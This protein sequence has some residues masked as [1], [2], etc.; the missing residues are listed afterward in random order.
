MKGTDT[1]MKKIIYTKYSNERARQ[2]AIRT[3]IL[4]TENGEKVVQKSACYPEG[5]M[6]IQNIFRWYQVL[7]E[8]YQNTPITMNRCITAEN[9]VE[10]Q[11]LEGCTMEELLD[12]LLASQEYEL[13]AKTIDHYLTSIQKCGKSHKFQVTP[14][15]VEVFGEVE[16]PAG[17]YCAPVTNIDMVFANVI[18]NGSWN[19]ID[20]EWTFDFPIPVNY[21][22]Y[23]ILHYYVGAGDKRS[24]IEDDELYQKLNIDS[25]EIVQYEKMEAHFQ[26]HIEKDHV[27]IRNLYEDITPGRLSVHE[28]INWEQV[29]KR[30][31]RIQIFYALEGDFC[32]EDS[33]S[34]PMLQGRAQVR[35]E[36]PCGVKKLR[37]DPGEQAGILTIK[38][39]RLDSREEEII[40]YVANGQMQGLHR[41]LYATTDPQILLLEIPADTRLLEV[42]LQMDAASMEVVSFMQD[43]EDREDAQLKKIQ[44]LE[45]I[46]VQKEQIVIEM[47][48][49]K[50]WK[51]YQKLKDTGRKDRQ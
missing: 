4:Q 48:N 44:E 51:A 47:E 25:D 46:L 5:T 39:L 42:E 37:L 23:R 13:A 41:V 2:Y 38:T 21:V 20:Y 18:I 31:R 43:L 40:P 14:E 3:D 35:M 36:L 33:R 17:L 8:Q 26:K 45:S 50:V 30:N 22:L 19:I 7:S 11:H 10:L 29:N 34:Y 24:K 1:V 12:K 49:T 15:F 16:L 27:P 6:H 28:L 9:G 32:E